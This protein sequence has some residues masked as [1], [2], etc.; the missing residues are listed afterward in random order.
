MALSPS[1]PCCNFT[2]IYQIHF[3]SPLEFKLLS[4]TCRYLLLQHLDLEP[5]PLPFHLC[6][7]GSHG[8]NPRL[9]WSTCPGL[10]SH[11]WGSNRLSQLLHLYE[12]DVQKSRLEKCSV[13]AAHLPFTDVSLSPVEQVEVV[14]V[15]SAWVLVVIQFSHTYLYIN[16][17]FLKRSKHWT[18]L[19]SLSSLCEL[20]TYLSE[21]TP[22][23]WLC[24]WWGLTSHSVYCWKK[25]PDLLWLPKHS[26]INTTGHC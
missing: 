19:N 26:V 21:Q 1:C 12:C 14:P 25:N 11:Y 15:V 5:P 20:W 6:G 9:L 8:F 7:S 10:W 24:M 4:T 17:M 23:H 13:S 16:V 3:L 18:A 2:L 22:L